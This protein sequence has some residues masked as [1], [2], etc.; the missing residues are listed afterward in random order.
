MNSATCCVD[1]ETNAGARVVLVAVDP[2]LPMRS[3]PLTDCDETPAP[4]VTTGDGELPDDP[5]PPHAARIRA[6]A[7]QTSVESF[8][9]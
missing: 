4:G 2:G 1:D 9:R 3:V 8:I 7:M 5:P 6:N